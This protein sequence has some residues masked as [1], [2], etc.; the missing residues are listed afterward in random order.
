MQFGKIADDALDL[1]SQLLQG[2]ALLTRV[3]LAG[4]RRGRTVVVAFDGEAGEMEAR[5]MPPRPRSAAAVANFT[6]N[7]AELKKSVSNRY[8]YLTALNPG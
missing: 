3:M 2:L 7:C 8:R 6:G 1:I 5:D 4:N